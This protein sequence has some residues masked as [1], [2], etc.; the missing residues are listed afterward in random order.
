MLG[1]DDMSEMV[2]I[3]AN[4][5]TDEMIRAGADELSTILCSL[6]VDGKWLDYEV[7]PHVFRAMVAVAPRL[8]CASPQQS[9]EVQQPHLICDGETDNQMEPKR[10]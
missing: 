2:F 10:G 4:V 5:L 9:P 6:D 7:I 8:V 1:V 3:D